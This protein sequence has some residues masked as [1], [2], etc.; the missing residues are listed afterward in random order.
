MEQVEPIN[1]QP[2]FLGRFLLILDTN[3]PPSLFSVARPVAA[4]GLLRRW[5]WKDT[6]M[7]KGALTASWAAYKGTPHVHFA[8][9]KCCS[10]LDGKIYPTT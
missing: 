6:I 1:G 9:L 5:R 7:I 8:V 4:G 10:S 3:R 2:G